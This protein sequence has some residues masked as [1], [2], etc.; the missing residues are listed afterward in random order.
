MLPLLPLPLA[1][2][3]RAQQGTDGGLEEAAGGSGKSLATLHVTAYEGIAS[4]VN[5]HH[6]A[7]VSVAEMAVAECC[8][9]L[10]EDLHVK[11]P[12]MAESWKD[13]L[14][15]VSETM[16]EFS[17]AGGRYE[18]LQQFTAPNLLSACRELEPLARTLLS[19]IEESLSAENAARAQEFLTSYLQR[20]GLPPD[21]RPIGIQTTADSRKSMTSRITRM[22][23]YGEYFSGRRPYAY[24]REFTKTVCA[25]TALIEASGSFS[26]VVGAVMLNDEAKVYS[27]FFMFQDEE[28]GKKPQWRMQG[29]IA[30]PF[31]TTAQQGQGRRGS[32]AGSA[33]INEIGARIK[34]QNTVTTV[35][36]AVA[37]S[38]P[39]F[40]KEKLLATEF[41][42][43]GGC[44]TRKRMRGP[45]EES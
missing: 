7:V 30:C 40:W 37:T 23:N 8:F 12:E 39:D 22:M 26:T 38:A 28:A 2:S 4:K 3:A 11:K 18:A 27:Q 20:R 25:S 21:T 13:L 44:E 32:G 42:N 15:D 19:S 41:I 10:L 36:V 1:P 9:F 33:L 43:C 6:Y 29:I 16:E 31:Y 34:E 45:E 35:A 24:S 17:A 5:T 14:E